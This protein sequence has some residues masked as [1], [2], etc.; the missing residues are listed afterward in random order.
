MKKIIILLAPFVLFG[1]IRGADNRK[2]DDNSE[3]KVTG[4]IIKKIDDV[5]KQIDIKD[6]IDNILVG[7]EPKDIEFQK[8]KKTMLPFPKK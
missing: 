7:R 1:C 6:N 2:G 3:M 8:E 5:S 4:P